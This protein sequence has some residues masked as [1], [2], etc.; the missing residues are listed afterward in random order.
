MVFKRIKFTVL[1]LLIVTF[2][3]CTIKGEPVIGKVNDEKYGFSKLVNDRERKEASVKPAKVSNPTNVHKGSHNPTPVSLAITETG[4][5][6]NAIYGIGLTE[7]LYQSHVIGKT[8]LE[9]ATTAF[10]RSIAM[11]PD[12][13]LHAVWSTGNDSIRQVLYSH[14]RNQGE[15]WSPSLV[16]NDGYYGYNASIAVDPNNGNFIFV[17]YAG[18]QNK[19][20]TISA[21]VSKSTDGGFSFQ[22]SVDLGN[23]NLY[24]NYPAI[25]I[26]H[27]GN[28]HVAFENHDHI[29]YNY[30]CDGGNT[31]FLV[32]EI[33]S[34]RLYPYC[35]YPTIALDKNGNPFVAFNQTNWMME[36]YVC[37]S[38]WRDMSKGEWQ[39]IP[40][41]EHTRVGWGYPIVT[42]MVFDSGNIGH[43]FYDVYYDEHNGSQPI[44][45]Y[46]RTWDVDNNV[47]S[48]PEE[49]LSISSD[50]STF[51]PSAG[52]DHNDQICLLYAD[53]LGVGSPQ[54]YKGTCDIFV[55][56]KI[57]GKWIFNNITDNGVDHIKKLPKAISTVIDGT[58]HFL[59][60]N[61]A[62]E[63]IH[64][65]G[66]PWPPAVVDPTPQLPD[67]YDLTGPFKVS[68]KT[69]TSPYVYIASCSLFVWINDELD[70][71]VDMIETLPNFWEVEF[72][73]DGRAGDEVKYQSK[74]TSNFGDQ[75]M[76]ITNSFE[77]LE[78]KNP[79]ADIL[80]VGDDMRLFDFYDDVLSHLGYI[81][82]F[83]SVNDH[84]GIDASVTTYGWKTII[85]AGS[86]VESV[87][88][89]DYTDDPYAEFLNGGG[90]LC[91]ASQDYI[92]A[93]GESDGEVIFKPGDFAY[94]FF[95]V[96]ECVND[97]EE[98]DS[99][100]LGSGDDPISK[101]FEENPLV[102]NPH[103][104]GIDNYIDWTIATEKG[105]DI[106]FAYTQG[107]GAGVLYDTGTYKTIFLPWMLSWLVTEKDNSIVPQ[108][109]AYILMKNILEWF[110]TNPTEVTI[111]KEEAAIAFRLYANYPNP[112][113]TS[114]GNSSTSIAYD[115]PKASHVELA[116][117]NVL[118][119]KIK[120]VFNGSRNAG[121]YIAIWDGKND[122]GIAVASG[123]YFYVIR[124]GD[125]VSNRKLLLVR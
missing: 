35:K 82:E 14:S 59:Y 3:V 79:N 5:G 90:N 67:T 92:W 122:M 71:A 8:T 106:F 110:G 37:Y 119:D 116:I 2:F 111:E 108:G 123:V 30:S 121:R 51:A 103:L 15:T 97:P 75:A 48:E 16:V 22:P 94:D 98:K 49:I 86:A 28:P 31:W 62:N 69:H 55:G 114:I 12:T 70:Q 77:I 118:G 60:T 84:N 56:T 19:G 104:T 113:S 23:L 66:Y 6:D 24:S 10:A 26:D 32:P 18:C 17:A 102:L 34:L 47:W 105:V 45:V 41:F 99:L 91:L 25:V 73:I 74:I 88:T 9:Y 46:Y 85:I 83:W 27:W 120:T 43:F 40:P 100:L 52:I 124:A 63:I 93:H 54:F 89:R 65:L 21:R 7:L 61:E 38:N 125:L 11:G 87:P 13:V 50:G 80:L 29:L 57:G 95:K 81:Y 4:I 42:S 20:E 96:I 107:H 72:T 53:N 117:Y 1:S 44:T 76:S 58:F 36:I 68:A 115:L 112:F 64:Q 33:V 78:P 39:Q 101:G 109:D